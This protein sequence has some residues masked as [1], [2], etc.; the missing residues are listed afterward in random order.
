MTRSTRRAVFILAALTLAACGQD[1]ISAPEGDAILA[2]SASDIAIANDVVSIPHLARD[3]TA[4]FLS[5][6]DSDGEAFV[7][8]RDVTADGP[9]VFLFSNP[10]TEPT[11]E[12]AFGDAIVTVRLLLV[13]L[14]F[15]VVLGAAGERDTVGPGNYDFG[16]APPTLLLGVDNRDYDSGGV[17]ASGTISITGWSEAQGGVLA[18]KI[19]G[20]L[21]ADDGA[22][23]DVDGVFNLV[24]PRAFRRSSDRPCDLLAQDCVEW[25][26]C[27]WVDDPP[28]PVCRL[29]GSGRSGD[30]C[31]QPESC[32]PG[33]ICR[34]GV[35]RRVCEIAVAEC[36]PDFVCVPWY[37]PAGYCAP[38]R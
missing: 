35:C 22:W 32:A 9:L 11:M 33:F 27:Y 24:L 1:P 6:T 5:A 2:D 23:I 29:P 38:P 34:V 19:K 30:A 8:A 37:G 14:D 31:L 25:E 13:E 26:A 21:T 4:Y 7:I 20:R 17:G 18:G 12:L 3:R 36:N 10:G 15:G 16:P 28:A